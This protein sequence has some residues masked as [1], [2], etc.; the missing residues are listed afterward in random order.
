MEEDRETGTLCGGTAPHR[1]IWEDRLHGVL[2]V[3]GSARTG[4]YP[5]QVLMRRRN[6]AFPPLRE[7][8]YIR[9]PM[10]HSSYCEEG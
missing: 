10:M 4:M 3:P 1:R 9:L 7:M 8:L 2:S 6:G 5:P